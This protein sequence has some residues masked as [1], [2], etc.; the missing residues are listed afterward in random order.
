[1]R[2]KCV[3][4]VSA[5]P[6]RLAEFYRTVLGANTNEFHGRP[7]R[8]EMW[9]GGAPGESPD[10]GTVLIVVNFDADYTRRPT[11][12]CQ[13]VELQVSDVDAEYM[14]VQALGVDVKES[15]KDLPWG[16]RYFHIKDHDGN[17]ID[18]VQAL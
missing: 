7:H 18:L 2:L 12:A 14:R 13:G 16:Y 4:L 8:I 10:E 9:C 6:E 3:N 17:G 15:P 11:W 1:V 5:N